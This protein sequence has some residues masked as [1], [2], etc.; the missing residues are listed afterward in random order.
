MQSLL[1]LIISKSVRRMCCFV[2][3]QRYRGP[4]QN[5]PPCRACLNRGKPRT[6]ILKYVAKPHANRY[7]IKA[8]TNYKG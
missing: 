2:S 4:S 6:R 5:L 8:V 7:H 1:S 3:L